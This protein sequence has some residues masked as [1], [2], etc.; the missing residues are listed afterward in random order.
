MKEVLS[1]QGKTPRRRVFAGIGVLACLAVLSAWFVDVDFSREK[2]GFFLLRGTRAGQVKIASDLYLGEEQSVITGVSFQSESDLVR[3]ETPGKHLELKWD[4]GAGTGYIKNVLADGTILVT[5]FS[6]YLDSAGRKNHGL[7]I[8]GALSSLLLNQN[9]SP[10]NDSGMSWFDGKQWNHIWCNTN[11]GIGSTV[12][13]RSYPPSA[14]TYLGSEI[15]EQSAQR[16]VLRSRHEVVVD[17]VPLR[18]ERVVEALA[19]QPYLD[20]E[21]SITNAG[22]AVSNYFY[23]YGDE[24]W[25]GDFG[26]SAGDV[27]WVPKQ[28]IEY[29]SMFDPHV[30]SYAGMADFGSDALHEGHNFRHVANF[31]EWFGPNRPNVVFF[32]N[33]F[34]GFLHDPGIKVPLRGDTR[35]LGMYWGPRQLRAGESHSIAIAIG[36]AKTRTPS[37]P[38]EKPCVEPPH[39]MVLRPS[40]GCGPS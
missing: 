37:A 36:K 26:N 31:V 10:V 3:N 17:D 1:L 19:G 4:S 15:L 23:Y 12:S 20:L 6:R 35:S 28:L 38:P 8:G 40:Q 24:P 2:N 33:Q 18:I 34:E 16:I 14:W 21:V 11:E 30:V 39:Q 9:T 5:Q 25:I 27:G 29:E 13:S 22:G 32:A 7:F